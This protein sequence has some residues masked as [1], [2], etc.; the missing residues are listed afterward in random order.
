MTRRCHTGFWVAGLALAGLTIQADAWNA[1]AMAQDGPAVAAP[2]AEMSS[3]GDAALLMPGDRLRIDLFERIEPEDDR[4]AAR[5]RAGRPDQSFYPRQD[6]TGEFVVQPDGT[7]PMPLI[8]NIRAEGRSG[9]AV[10]ESIAATFE[11]VIG[12]TARVTQSLVERPPVSIVGPV[13]QPGIFR[14]VTGMT[15]QHV[16]ALAGGLR[17]ADDNWVRVEYAREQA[18]IPAA[19]ERFQRLQVEVQLLRAEREGD[20]DEP[21]LRALVGVARNLIDEARNGR[22]RIREAYAERRATLD[23]AAVAAQEALDITQDRLAAAAVGVKHREERLKA[24]KPLADANNIGKPVYLEAS[25]QLSEANERRLAASGL[26][27]DAR[28]RLA[29]AQSELSRF[30]LDRRVELDRLLAQRLQ[31]MGEARTALQS[32]E[33]VVTLLAPE[34]E[35]DTGALASFDFE[36][37]RRRGNEWERITATPAA[38]VEPGDLIKF[39]INRNKIVVANQ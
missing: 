14:Y 4:W 30:E 26:V 15:V 10:A 13:R 21:N 23:A 27:A 18:R 28:L 35:A 2:L 29:G 1:T 34:V 36:I 33:S 38:V 9:A 31:E 11:A 17:R 24:L 5:R 37:V 7:L 22:Q 32:S 6:M 20:G 19:R 12:R 39:E 25:V 8:G 16:L 3:R